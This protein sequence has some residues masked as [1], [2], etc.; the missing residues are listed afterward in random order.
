MEVGSGKSL[1][2]AHRRERTHRRSRRKGHCTCCLAV[3]E[4]DPNAQRS[5]T[6]GQWEGVPECPLPGLSHEVVGGRHSLRAS[7][8][9]RDVGR[10]QDPSWASTEAPNESETGD[11]GA[12]HHCTPLVGGDVLE[13][14]RRATLAS[15]L[16]HQPIIGR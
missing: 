10:V 1:Q 2:V 4:D 14:S 9:D 13:I 11:D 7:T 8:A 15:L 16:Q 5:A 6:K 12:A 3:P